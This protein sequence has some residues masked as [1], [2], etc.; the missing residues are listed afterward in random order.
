MINYMA[1]FVIRIHVQV[2]L[3]KDTTSTHERSAQPFHTS[4]RPR[5]S[6]HIPG[7]GIMFTGGSDDAFSVLESAVVMCIRSL[8]KL[9][10]LE[11]HFRLS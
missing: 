2:S 6:H 4:Q 8:R 9:D 11:A 7:Q 10:L 1:D 5:V 3:N